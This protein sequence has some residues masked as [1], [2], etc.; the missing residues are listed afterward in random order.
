MTNV[1]QDNTKHHKKAFV[2]LLPFL[3]VACD[4]D[5]TREVIVEVPAEIPPPVP[6]SYDVTVTN[7]T[8]AQPL[9][10]PAVVLHG[11]DTLWQIGDVASVELEALAL[12]RLAIRKR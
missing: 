12:Y 7:L 4:D 11:D 5:D 9:S 10:P 8:N 3:L 1:F 6:V 2:L